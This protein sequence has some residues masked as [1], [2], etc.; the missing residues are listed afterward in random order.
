MGDHGLTDFTDSLVNLLAAAS[1][2]RKL[3]LALAYTTRF[4]PRTFQRPSSVFGLRTEV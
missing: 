1:C 4:L 2:A 3:K